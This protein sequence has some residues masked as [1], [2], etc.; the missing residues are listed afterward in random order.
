MTRVVL[1]GISRGEVPRYTKIIH[2]LP[3]YIEVGARWG[4]PCIAQ[5]SRLRRASEIA[6]NAISKEFTRSVLF[7]VLQET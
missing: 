1:V 6:G 2:K 7:P 5:Y 4:D 3:N